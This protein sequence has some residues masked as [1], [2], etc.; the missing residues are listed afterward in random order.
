M[1]KFHKIEP[2]INWSSS[3]FLAWILGRVVLWSVLE[4]FIRYDIENYDAQRALYGMVFLSVISVLLSTYRDTQA[5][6]K[7]GVI[8]DN[9]NTNA[10]TKYLELVVFGIRIALIGYIYT[11]WIKEGAYLLS[12][13]DPIIVSDMFLVLLAL[14][15]GVAVVTGISSYIIIWEPWRIFIFRYSERLGKQLPIS[16]IVSRCLALVIVNLL[17][18]WYFVPHLETKLPS[19]LTSIGCL[20]FLI[21]FHLSNYRSQVT[22]S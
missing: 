6:N 10:K 8:V 19:V 11:Y 13:R 17:F 5:K 15:L 7:E 9:I 21:K 12:Q 14:G 20:A 22:K 3:I 4:Y 2:I 16:L 18:F 1:S